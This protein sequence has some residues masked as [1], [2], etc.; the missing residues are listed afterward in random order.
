ML[1]ERS[2]GAVVFR[3]ENGKR[4]YLLLHYTGGYWDFPKGNIEKGETEEQTTR[5]EIEE[6]AGIKDLVF[7]P[8]FKEKIKYF[9]KREGQQINKEVVY[10][11]AETKTSAIKISWE[12]TGFEWLPFREALERTAFNNSKAI[13]K[14]AEALLSGEKGIGK[15]LK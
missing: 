15:F 12:H 8:D 6:E 2:A 4:L 7:V 11:L 9:Y 1:S 3:A 13:L 5:R 10:F 14:K